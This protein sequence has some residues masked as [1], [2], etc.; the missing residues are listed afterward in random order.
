[1]RRVGGVRHVASRQLVL[2]LGAGFDP[3]EFI[4]D[5]VFDRLVVAELEMEERMVLDRSPISAV[6]RLATDK[7]DSPGNPAPCAARRHKQDAI[8]HLVANDGKKIAREIGP[9]PF[10]R[11]GFHIESKEGIPDRF[12][13]IAAGQPMHLN[14]CPQGLLALAPDGLALA[15]G[16]RTKKILEARIPSFVQVKWPVCALKKASPAKQPPFG[17]GQKR[18]MG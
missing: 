4:R 17:F 6:K 11:A 7:I 5:R 1:M 8:A 12:G 13:Q 2:A 16:R 3:L 10:A 9:P 14:T 15:G 18:E